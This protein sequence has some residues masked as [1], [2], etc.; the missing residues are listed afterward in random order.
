MAFFSGTGSRKARGE[1]AALAATGLLVPSL[2]VSLGITRTYEHLG[3]YQDHRI[4]LGPELAHRCHQ[5]RRPLGALRRTV[6]PGKQ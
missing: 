2:G 4:S 3:S 5:Q 1:C 6:F